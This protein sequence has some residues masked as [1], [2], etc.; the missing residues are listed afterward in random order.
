MRIGFYSAG[1]TIWLGVALGLAGGPALRLAEGQVE[2]PAPSVLTNAAAVRSLPPAV[3]AQR[4]PVRLRGVATYVFDTQ[5]CFV[6]DESSGI[7]VGAG[8]PIP[9]FVSGDLVEVEGVTGPGEYAPIVHPQAARRVGHTNLPPPR[10][11]SYDELVTGREDSQWVEVAGLVRAVFTEPAIGCVLEIASGSGRLIVFVPSATESNVTHLVD[12][13]VRVKGVCGTWFNKQRQL[14]GIR[15]MVSHTNDIIVEEAAPANE[16]AQPAQP[17]GNLMRFTP[18]ASAYGRRAKVTGTVILHQPGRALYVQDEEYGLYVQ[19]RQSGQLQA[20]DQ[21]ELLGFPGKGD[22][23]PTLQDGVWQKVGSGPDPNPVPVNPDDAL[24]GLQDSR[25]VAIEGRLLDHTLNNNEVVLLLE[26]NDHIFSPRL[27]SGPAIVTMPELQ[28]GS[29]LRVV[30]VCRIEVG[31]TW[32]SG[33]TWRAKSFH[34][35]LRS[36]ADIQVLKL[37]PWW[38]LTRLLWAVG[39]LVTAMV[40]SL[41]WV[42]QLRNKVGKQTTIIR[43]QLGMEAKLKE[44]YQDLFENA[45]DMVY[46]HD[47][48]GRMTSI[49]VAGE[50]LLGRKRAAVTQCSL[51]DFIAEE[52]RLPASQWLDHIVDGTAPATVEWDFVTA[53]GGQV[54]LEISTR[55]IEREGRRVEVEGIARDVTEQ[56][57][58]QKEILEI[59]TREQRRIGHDLHDG[60]CQQLAGIGFLSDILATKLHQQNRPEAAQADN[61]SELVNQANKQTRSVARGLFPIRLEE[62]GL[63]SALEELADNADAL[64]NTPCRFHCDVPIVIHDHSVAHHLYYITQ[65]AILN[66]VKHGQARS[67]EVQLVAADDGGYVLAVRNDGVL[68]ATPPA[69][70]RGMGIRIM[71]YRARMIGASLE[72]RALPGAGAEV[73]CRFAGEPRLKG[74]LADSP[75]RTQ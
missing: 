72:I 13:Q 33:P 69:H 22:Y 52:Q 14:F 16:L 21:V 57:R 1:R 40:A 3:A 56:R 62:N 6:Q 58:L 43:Q 37:P 38:T 20:G 63:V 12:S 31:E 73:L 70:G 4:L 29:R 19:T 15:L 24:G 8:E 35:L 25:L 61:I 71:K 10:R 67:I 47:L 2:S 11:V 45:N 48:S 28:N 7:F 53:T 32:R 74:T 36:P 51:L 55:I 68:F 23:T 66:A 64:F 54:R 65:E 26:A 17:I 60:V 59:S 49:N 46:T 9:H 27:E 30:G 34:I 50:R 44:R 42:S 39:M 75:A 18:L 41:V 5:A